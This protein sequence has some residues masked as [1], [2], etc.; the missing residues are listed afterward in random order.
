MRGNMKTQAP[1]FIV[2]ILLCSCARSQPP[3]QEQAEKVLEQPGEAAEPEQQQE[4]EPE[5]EM[6]PE[7]EPPQAPPQEPE[8]AAEP[9]PEQAPTQESESN[10][11]VSE[12]V[13]TKT[14]DEIEEFI[15]NLNEIIRN[16]DYDT[17]LTYLSEEYI[18]RTSDPEYLRRQSEQPMLKKNNID[19][20][21][22][23]DYFEYVV[24]PSRNMA[25]LDEIEF[26]DENHVKA[27]A[28]IRNTKAL[29]YLLVRENG[30]WKI[31]VS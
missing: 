31:G 30:M 21:N 12:E 11:V 9:E 15:R 26:I 23:K 27:Y 16:E 7:V 4:V 14:F 13:Y 5:A 17:W 20:R 2:A 6:Q 18:R 24:V 1:L 3:A 29:L 19:L 22:L 10:F 25:Q 28:M 8:Q